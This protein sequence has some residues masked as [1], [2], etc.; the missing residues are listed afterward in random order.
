MK[1]SVRH[2]KEYF[3]ITFKRLPHRVTG[4]FVCKFSIC[5]RVCV[6]VFETFFTKLINFEWSVL[7]AQEG[8]RFQGL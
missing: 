2:Q 1:T 3:K 7:S 5:S 8:V 4:Y 6:C